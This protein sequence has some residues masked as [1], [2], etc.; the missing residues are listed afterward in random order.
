MRLLTTACFLALSSAMA[1]APQTA[2]ADAEMRVMSFNIR[3]ASANDGP[4]AWA[5]RK[6]ILIDTIKAFDPD[7]LGTQE[8][9]AIQRDALA[10][11]LPDYDVLA[12][13]RDDGR[14]KGEMM[15]LF[16]RKSRFEK[17]GGGH[18]WLSESHAVAGSKSWDSSLPRMV[19][20]VKL[21]DRKAPD[22]K[23]IAFFN[24]HFDH[25]GV[26]ARLE[27]ARLIRKQLDELGAGCRV[28]VTGD[29]NCAEA[30]EPYAAM[31]APK[32]DGSPV[33]LDTYRIRNPQRSESEGTYSGFRADATK[34]ARIDWIASSPDW[35]VIDASIDRTA[36]NGRTPSDH[37]PIYAVLG[38][39]AAVPASKTNSTDRQKL[40]ILSYNIHHG[41]GLDDKV[42][43]ER[44]A[45]V[46]REAKP[47]L[48]ALQ[49]VDRGTT[50]TG[51]VDQTAEL[52]R[53]TGLYGTFGKAIDYAGGDYG[54]AILARVPIGETKIHWLPGEPDRERRI[55]FE[56]TVVL[57]GRAIRFVTTHLHH[58]NDEF[59]RRQAEALNDIYQSDDTF[60]II[61]GDL[62]AYPQSEPLKIFRSRW[63]VANDAEGLV[64][65]PAEKPNRLIDY[66]LFKPAKDV[67][68][69]HQRVID[70]PMAS[71]HRPVIVELE[72]T[73][74]RTGN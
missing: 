9:L 69:T 22:A 2:L 4:N 72:W 62:N 61:A 5:N 55:A 68:V 40:R 47:D 66:V 51:K 13:G 1:S 42:D 8:T 33:L 35:S 25:R 14:E 73:A 71:D 16:Y 50:R 67:K 48:V 44:I 3:Y 28:I 37:F 30:S 54:Q 34:G 39:P 6:D 60:T 26:K 18:F 70:E 53:L 41:R 23:P 27:S 24:T 15:A 32:P 65:F 58:A 36:R 19:T 45:K 64:S 17:I 57:D 46:I 74:A 29:F 49:E 52:A 43:L 7:L 20:W 63:T 12:V 10:A 56:T 31:F 59:R 21:K 38:S 11:A